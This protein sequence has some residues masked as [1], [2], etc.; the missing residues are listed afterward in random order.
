MKVTFQ[1]ITAIPVYAQAFKWGRLLAI[2]DS[3]QALAQ[4][5]GLISGIIVIRLLPIQEYALYT[6]ANTMLGTMIVLAN[7]GLLTGLLAEG[8]KVWQN[9]QKFGIVLVTGLKIRLFL[10]LVA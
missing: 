5:L 10:L 9:P 2:T 3:K 4:A 6:L 7:S 8:G 1:R